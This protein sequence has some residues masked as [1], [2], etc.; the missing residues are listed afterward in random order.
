MSCEKKRPKIEIYTTKWIPTI[1]EWD[2]ADKTRYLVRYR[3][4][5][6][7]LEEEYIYETKDAMLEAIINNFESTKRS[8]Q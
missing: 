1:Y 3:S 5:Y 7:E 2:M 6:H 4:P 8:N